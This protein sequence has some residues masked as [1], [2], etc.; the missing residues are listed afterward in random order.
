MAFE[1]VKRL[2][3]RFSAPTDEEKIANL[4]QRVD[5]L[6]AQRDRIYG[7]T[8]ALEQRESK[9]LEEG[10][11][12]KSKIVRKRLASQ[13]LQVRRDLQRQHTTA[14]MINGQVDILGTD[15][16]HLTLLQQ[17]TMAN[18]N[19]SRKITENAVKA[20]EILESLSSDAALV[21]ALEPGMELASQEE[22]DILKEFDEPEDEP[23]G[24]G[25]TSREV[26]LDK[27]D[28]ETEDR[29]R[30]DIGYPEAMRG[31]DP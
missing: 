15:I 13:L 26:W 21:S 27:P 23:E 5:V 3:R 9:L 2:T 31:C 20:E 11:A 10:K 24:E 1:R 8:T 12:N 18:L 25:P 22:L 29:I 4:Q 28:E 6:S 7:D 30:D 17:G 16:H 19:D 14:A